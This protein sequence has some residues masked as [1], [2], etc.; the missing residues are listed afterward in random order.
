MDFMCIVSSWRPQHYVWPI[1]GLMTT[2]LHCVHFG[3][4][5]NADFLVVLFIS[6]C[7]YRIVEL[8]FL[9]TKDRFTLKHRNPLADNVGVS[10][11]MARCSE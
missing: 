11:R 10:E 4:T 9:G 3:I 1:D 7:S 8:P 2:R 6:V 5:R